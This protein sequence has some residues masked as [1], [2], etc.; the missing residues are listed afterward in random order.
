M[1][2]TFGCG[3]TRSVDSLVRRGFAYVALTFV[4]G[5]LYGLSL[6]AFCLRGPWIRLERGIARFRRG[7][8]WAVDSAG[9]WIRPERGFA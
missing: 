5:G 2:A 3:F 1:K 8:A 4:C 6:P 9:A 7:F